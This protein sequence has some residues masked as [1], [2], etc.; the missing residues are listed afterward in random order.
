VNKKLSRSNTIGEMMD[1][2]TE[3]SIKSLNIIKPSFH[4][5]TSYLPQDWSDNTTDSDFNL[6]LNI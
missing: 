4:K 5:T 3:D 2:K 1:K 6:I